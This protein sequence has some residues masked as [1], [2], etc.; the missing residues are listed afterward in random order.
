MNKHFANIHITFQQLLA[1]L[2]GWGVVGRKRNIEY[3]TFI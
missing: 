2:M 3:Y 1:V